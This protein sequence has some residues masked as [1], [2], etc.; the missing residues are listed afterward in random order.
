MELKL[1]QNTDEKK[2]AQRVDK[3]FQTMDSDGNGELSKEEFINGAKLD[4][5]IVSAFNCYNGLV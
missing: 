1:G 5:T 3:I 4:K 2:V